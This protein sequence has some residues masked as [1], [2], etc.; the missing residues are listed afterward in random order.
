V[1]PNSR[2]SGKS[3]A[4]SAWPPRWLTPVPAEDISRGDGDYCADFIG[5]F[6]RITKDSIGGPAGKLISVLPEQRELF[7]HVFARRPDGR[8]RHRTVLIG[9][10][11]KNAKS[12]EC[13]G[14]GIFGLINGPDGGEVYSCAAEKE[15]A[16]IVFGTAK[17]MIEMDPELSEMTRVYRDAIEVPDT[18][19]VYRVLSAEAFTKEG[20]NPHLV[21]FDEVHAQPNRE[22]WDVMSLAMGS[23]REPMLVGITTAGVMTDSTGG[24]SVCYELYQYGRRVALGEIDDATFF[25]AWWEPRDPNA[26]HRDPATWREANPG[27]GILVDEEDFHS[28]VRRTPEA[29]FRTKRC[30][31]WVTTADTWLP[32]GSFERLGRP[33]KTIPKRAKVVLGFDGSR[34]GDATAL[35]AVSVEERPHVQLVEL[36]EKPKDVLDWKVPREEVKA[37]IRERAKYWDVPEIAWDEYLWL[38]ALDE[39]TEEGLLIEPFGQTIS[40]MG[41]ATQRMYEAVADGTITHDGDPRLERHFANCATKTDARG[42]RIVKDKPGSPRKIDAA[43]AA[44]MALERAAWHF[45]NGPIDISQH[46]W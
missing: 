42:T 27:F 14:M 38:D 30:N 1:S 22:L 26:D 34:N 31:Q 5:D 12:T 36:W 2:N 35:V 23:R 6:C 41:P 8:Y 40:H 17:R 10:P 13:A 16:R 28:A 4:P 20:L 45:N 11:R 25:M 18:G 37:V 29:E 15:Q 39:L 43:V 44:T 3:T 9:K 24:D 21:L 19:S 46:I 7:G 33:G 32:A